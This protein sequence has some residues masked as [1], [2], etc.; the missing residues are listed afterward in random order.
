[1]KRSRINLFKLT[2][3]TISVLG[4]LL[5]IGTIL[6]FAY[7]GVDT[8][9]DAISSSV[10]KGAE[11]DE[12]AKLQSD[13][14]SLKVQY[15]SVKKEVYQRNNDNLTRTYLNAEIELVKARSAIDDVKSALE[16]SKPKSEVDERIKTTRY[17]L[18]VAS[19]ALSDVRALM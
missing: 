4:V 18:Q 7:I 11:Y 6:V 5:I 9:S 1:M 14:S 10:D 15:D 16:T 19:Q 2:S 3:M 12:L 13:Y 8:I 17:Q